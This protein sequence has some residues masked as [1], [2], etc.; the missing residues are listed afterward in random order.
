MINTILGLKK[1][2]TAQFDQHGRRIP[3]TNI[4]AEPNVVLAIKDGRIQL[5][6]G[7]KKKFK[8]TENAYVKNVGYAP[9]FIKEVKI[10]NEKQEIKIGD[11]MTVSVF[12]LGD[13]VKVTG[14]TLGKGFTGVVK[15]WGFAGGPKT[16]GQSDRHRAPGSIGQTTTP[17]RVF[18][19]KKMAGHMGVGKLTVTGLEVVNIDP[20]KN[21]LEVK[22]SVPG[23]RNGFLIIEKTGKLKSYTSAPPPK[24]KEEETKA[25]EKSEESEEI[26]EPKGE[27]KTDPKEEK[28]TE[29]K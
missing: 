28:E 6:F 23:S 19:G 13:L 12:E 25:K 10:D 11:K 16:H 24:E 14:I 7:R 5:G 17:G 20:A 9:R 8:K 3:V 15:R 1:G 26:K 21:L 29:E 18:K 27:S 2:M 22:G 4:V